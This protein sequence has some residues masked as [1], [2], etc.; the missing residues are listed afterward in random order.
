MG[1]TTTTST[2]YTTSTTTMGTTT[3]MD[4]GTPL[5]PELIMDIIEG[6]V[7]YP[8]VVPKKNQANLS[9]RRKKFMAALD[10]FFQN[11]LVT[12]LSK[13]C[14]T[15]HVPLAEPIT[16]ARSSSSTAIIKDGFIE[17]IKPTYEN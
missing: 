6:K 8:N 16:G 14:A 3:S 2:T 1:E 17:S 9:A 11:Y 10:A 12:G 4:A 13:K 7:K 15:S 5:T